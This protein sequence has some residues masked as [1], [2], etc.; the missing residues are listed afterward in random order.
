MSTPL[1]PRL[2]RAA[3]GPT[4]TTPQAPPIRILHIG[5]GAF[6]RAHQAWYTARAADGNLWGIAAFAGRSGAL[7]SL[8]APQDGVFTLVERD[9]D[10]DRFHHVGSIAAAY[11]SPESHRLIGLLGSRQTSVVT[12]TVTEA[13]YTLG[14]DGELDDGNP[15]VASDI[16]VL[17]HALREYEGPAAPA[18]TL[19]R[20]VAGL[21]RRRLTGAGPLAIVPCDNFSDNGPLTRAAV[22]QMAHEVQPELGAW[23]GESVSF[24]STSVDRITPRVEDSLVETVAAATGYRD[25]APIA[26][27][28]FSD[29][30]LSGEF[31][32]GRP[33]W[34][35]SGAVFVDEIGPYESRKLWMLNG[36]HSL[37][38]YFGRLLGHRTVAEA[39]RDRDC[40]IAVNAWWDEACR[41]LPEPLDLAS[42]RAALM[43]RFENP[44][45]EHSLAQISA[46][47]LTKISL[48][49]APV[50]RAERRAGRDAEAAAFVMAAWIAALRNGL[51]IDDTRRAE[52]D[53]ALAAV[54]P[55]AA[56]LAMVG[57]ELAG[58]TDFR[59][60]V[61]DVVHQLLDRAERVAA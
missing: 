39:V 14:T 13:G 40:I 46:D 41:H 34:E 29:W 32:A 30:T 49:I 58:D 18:T 15:L 52:I 12:M 27:E 4:G 47:G 59:E 45:I 38:A 28:P 8:L 37:L 2:S 17:K 6:H 61:R 5:L 54:D 23:I 36:A 33:D 11:S 48:R 25:A 10:G 22:I 31:P 43:E 7:P 24:V 57:P 9:R 16:A 60:R 44:R 56:L 20:L 19:G 53:R 50:A 51:P 42:Y 55:T 26:T 1:L 3:L 35:S 21:A